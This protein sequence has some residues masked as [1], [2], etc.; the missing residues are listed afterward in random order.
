MESRYLSKLNFQ[1]KKLMLLKKNYLLEVNKNEH[2]QNMN[3][4]LN[5]KMGYHVS[6]N[7]IKGRDANKLL[8][9]D[10]SH[11]EG[12]K[13]LLEVKEDGY[14]KHD[15]YNSELEVVEEENELNLPENVE[16]RT[17]SLMYYQQ[18]DQ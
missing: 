16:D 7:K 10:F 15:F 13:K 18:M 12:L 6:T 17:L 9:L 11:K 2:L 3:N 1:N 14:K 8:D 4:K 5:E